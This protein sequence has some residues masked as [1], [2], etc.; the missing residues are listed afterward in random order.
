MRTLPL[1]AQQFVERMAARLP[2]R[3][4]SRVRGIVSPTGAEAEGWVLYLPVTAQEM[5]ARGPEYARDRLREATRLAARLGASILG[6]GG[7][8]KEVTMETSTVA[9]EVSIPIT[10][11]TSYLVSA[12]LWAAKQAVLAIG[13]EQDEVGRAVGTTLVAGA[14]DPQ[15]SVAA[16]LA[17]LVFHRVVLVDEDQKALKALAARIQKRSPHCEVVCDQDHLPHLAEADLV[18]TGY[19]EGWKGTID[20]QQLRC[21]AVLCDFS[22]PTVWGPEAADE[23]P[24]VLFIRAGEIELPGPAELGVDLGPPRK[25]A[26]ASMA[27]TI[28]LA[29][30]G[31][32]C[33]Y[34]VGDQV[35]FGRVKDIYKMGLKHGMQLAG[36]RGIFGQ[37]TAFD[38]KMVR[39]QV[40]R[41]KRMQ[42]Q[43]PPLESTDDE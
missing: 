4:V 19:G 7:F 20:L 1:E 25:V 28:V 30:E 40:E 27:E 21:G 2:I 24:D 26:F 38:L 15:G 9:R 29:L 8:A 35:E 31:E 11:G 6:V 14:A 37:L 43:P 36:M 41:R 34:S 39:E 17:A 13:I 22:R 23:R 10:S 12:D 16:E 42:A 5:R 3:A 32:Y 18:V 33:C